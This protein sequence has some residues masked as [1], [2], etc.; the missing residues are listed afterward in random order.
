M[1][2]PRAPRYWLPR[3]LPIQASTCRTAAGCLVAEFPA[4]AMPFV[5]LTRPTGPIG[6]GTTPQRKPAL[7]GDRG[8][9]VGAGLEHR[10]PALQELVAGE[11]AVAIGV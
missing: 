5:T 11:V 9:V 8:Q 1:A 10:H 6:I 7:F 4:A 2:A 3:V